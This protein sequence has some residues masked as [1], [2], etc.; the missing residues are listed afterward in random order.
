MEGF[1][2]F[3]LP[4]ANLQLEAIFYLFTYCTGVWKDS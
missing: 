4:V 1:L 3:L 2:K